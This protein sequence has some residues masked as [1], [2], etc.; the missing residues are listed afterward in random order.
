MSREAVH[1]FFREIIGDEGLI[2]EL[3]HQETE[4]MYLEKVVRTGRKLGYA[5]AAKDVK[6]TIEAVRQSDEELDD[7]QLE[8]AA[9]GA[10]PGPQPGAEEIIYRTVPDE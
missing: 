5:F 2:E 10:K 1:D 7:R 6:E 3:S 4:E 9:G 8:Q